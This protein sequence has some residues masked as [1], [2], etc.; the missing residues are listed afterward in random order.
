MITLLYQ[1]DKILV[2]QYWSKPCPNEIKYAFEKNGGSNTCFHRLQITVEFDFI[3]QS[4]QRDQGVFTPASIAEESSNHENTWKEISFEK[5]KIS[6]SFLTAY[7][8][9]IEL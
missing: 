9:N 7:I 3:T 4:K 6:L 5:K 1:R 2:E 8:F